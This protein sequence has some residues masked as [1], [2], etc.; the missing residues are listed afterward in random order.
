MILEST[1]QTLHFEF[2]TLVK[3]NINKAVF[4]V[5]K[6]RGVHKIYLEDDVDRLSLLICGLLYNGLNIIVY[7]INPYECESTELFQKKIL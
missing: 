7:K 6:F 4:C 3:A 2:I 5:K 1:K